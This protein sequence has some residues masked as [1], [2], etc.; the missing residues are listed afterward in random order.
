M[1]N[2]IPFLT[3]LCIKSVKFNNFIVYSSTFNY[4]VIF[5]Y[6]NKIKKDTSFPLAS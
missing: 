6:S 3:L 4:N 2:L 1:G 5:L